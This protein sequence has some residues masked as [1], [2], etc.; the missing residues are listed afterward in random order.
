MV[1]KK[2]FKIKLRKILLWIS[3]ILAILIIVTEIFFVW[4]NRKAF[5]EQIN[6]D[7]DRSFEYY[8]EMKYRWSD[9]PNRI[10]IPKLGLIAKI[11]YPDNET[12]MNKLLLE[13][14]TH[15]PGTALPGEKGN[16]VYTGHSSAPVESEYSHVFATLNRMRLGDDIYI[17]RDGQKYEYEVRKKNFVKPSEMSVISQEKQ[18]LTLLTCWPIG[19]DFKRLTIFAA[20]IQ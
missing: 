20:K 6:Y 11:T 16:T 14:V 18:G 12:E 8:E 2:Q 1:F 15:M 17:Y 19:T 13:S 7:K 10:E 5:L 3:F 9:E 4:V